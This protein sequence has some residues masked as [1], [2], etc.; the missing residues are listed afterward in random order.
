MA[1][2]GGR[3]F[4]LLSDF[5]CFLRF[6]RKE[7]CVSVTGVVLVDNIVVL[8]FFLKS[9][10]ERNK[11]KHPKETKKRDSTR[12]FENK[13]FHRFI[14]IVSLRRPCVS[15]FNIGKR[16]KRNFQACTS[17]CFSVETPSTSSAM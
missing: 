5:L 8:K 9:S 13:R 15:H 12:T 14:I 11:K 4:G 17:S 2:D 1:D 6:F 16:D 10:S 7:H 3:N